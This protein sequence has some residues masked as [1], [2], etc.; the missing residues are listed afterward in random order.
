MFADFAAAMNAWEVEA[1]ALSRPEN[2]G[3]EPHLERIRTGLNAIYARFLTAKERKT[4]RLAGPD[5]GFPPE[6][7]PA[8]ESVVGAEDLG[9]K[10]MLE[11][12]WTHPTMRHYTQRR[13]YTLMFAH[14]RW[15]IDKKETFSAVKGKWTNQVL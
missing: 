6:Y 13:R 14:D 4:G 1:Y 11:T 7:D 9:R 5:V 3:L 15:W 10:C 2:G 8:N 12:L